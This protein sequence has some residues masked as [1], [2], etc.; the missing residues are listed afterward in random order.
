LKALGFWALCEIDRQRAANRNPTLAAMQA[1]MPDRLMRDIVADQRRGVAEPSSLA[2]TPNAP[3]PAVRGTGWVDPAPLAP[4]PGVAIM[5]RML[6]A[7][8]ARDRAARIVD[9]ALDRARRGTIADTPRAAPE[10]PTENTP[11]PRGHL[12]KSPTEPAK[13]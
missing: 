8:D 5:D 7:Q 10:R 3:A 11:P 1:A 6:D 12:P 4:P 9:A 2:A 13:K